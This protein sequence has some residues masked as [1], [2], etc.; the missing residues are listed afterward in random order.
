MQ[1]QKLTQFISDPDGS[2]DPLTAPVF[3]FDNI[4]YKL[5]DN[6]TTSSINA[7]VI[8]RSNTVLDGAGFTLTGTNQGGSCG[9]QLTSI[10]NVTIRNTSIQSFYDGVFEEGCSNCQIVESSL[11][12]NYNGIYYEFSDFNTIEG[13]NITSNRYSGIWLEISKNNNIGRNGLANTISSNHIGGIYL[14]DA[15]NNNDIFDNNLVDNT[16]YGIY[17][18]N[19]GFNTIFHN[20]F[21]NNTLHAYCLESFGNSME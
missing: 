12:F 17:I 5:T 14:Q 10:S 1:L 3:S 18:W 20:N 4:T 9:I 13:N 15:S 19:S 6:I 21:I 2:I 8:E 11:S 16:Y 7:I